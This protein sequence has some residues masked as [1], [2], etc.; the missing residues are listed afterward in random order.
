MKDI[1]LTSVCND[2]YI[3]GAKVMLYSMKKNINNLDRCDFK[4]YYNDN[5]SPLS[6]ENKQS[7]KKIIPNIIIEHVD[8]E[9]YL[10]SKIPYDR[11]EG[12]K[13][14]YLTLES[15]NETEYNKVILFDVDMLCIGDISDLFDVDLQFG[16]FNRNTGFVVLG[17]SYR[18]QEIYDRLTSKIQSH[19]GDFMDQGII[20]NVF[21][22]DFQTI[23]RS[24]N[25]YPL[26]T[27]TEDTRILH[28]AHYDH[29]KPWRIDE[30]K[31]KI[32]LFL[33]E[34]EYRNPDPNI[35]NIPTLK[36]KPFFD[37][38]EEYRVEMG[39]LSEHN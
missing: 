10:N 36:C 1:L 39:G 23:S 28:W 15:F 26:S 31:D 5:V 19:N 6:E 12:S 8:N 16:I 35:G 24:Y 7:L 30:W 25:Q 34:P 22:N 18:N 3:D 29:V 13:A 4:I 14:A 21:I 33:D 17:K 37:L 9:C 38:W 20:N 27:K 32:E 2:E 11:S